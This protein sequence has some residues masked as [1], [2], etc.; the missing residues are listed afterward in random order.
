MDSGLGQTLSEDGGQVELDAVS[1]VNEGMN[2]TTHGSD[3]QLV[4][5]FLEQPSV[6]GGDDAFLFDFMHKEDEVGG[7]KVVLT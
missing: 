6:E 4:F 5:R 2:G 7:I 3:E 1:D